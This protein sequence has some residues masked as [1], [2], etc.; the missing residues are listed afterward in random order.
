[1]LVQ[2]SR[3]PAASFSYEPF[4]W[5]KWN[6]MDDSVA[7]FPRGLLQPEGS[8]RFAAD[9]LLLAA[10]AR[11][12]RNILRLADVGTG[13]GVVAF[14]V[15]LRHPELRAVGFEREA[16]L[17][18]AAEANAARL[19][20]E[21]RFTCVH[22]DLSALRPG[23][24][25]LPADSSA[26]SFAGAFD[27]VLANPPY[28]TSGHGREPASVLR[29]NARFHEDPLG[30]FCGAAFHFLRDKGRFCMVFP[31]FR[32]A[33]LCAA[34]SRSRLAPR[35]LLPVFPRAG[36]PAS[37]VLLEA[38]KNVR[39]DIRFEP[40]LIL[41]EGTG[42]CTRFTAAALEFCPDLGEMGGRPS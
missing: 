19:G 41:H 1:M 29:R 15:L 35:R 11:P 25:E 20:L 12:G 33:D 37:L 22:G 5:R 24:D 14:A 8:F 3:S 4:A 38:R 17:A 36:E 34:L 2:G 23:R 40:P 42:A 16:V 27:L 31:A 21:D 6:A 9:A 39:P 32:L 18:A 13:C 26:R 7:R 30:V 28:H 10:F